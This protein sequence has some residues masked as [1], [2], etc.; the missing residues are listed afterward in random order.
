MVPAE[1][2]T[3]AKRP[4]L[5]VLFVRD[6]CRVFVRHFFATADHSPMCLTAPVAHKLTSA[7]R[8]AQWKSG[9]RVGSK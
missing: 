5:S 2:C 4:S 8:G 6:C 9:M 7:K 1:C 3:N